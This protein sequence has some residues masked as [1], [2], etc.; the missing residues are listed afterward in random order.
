M[1]KIC[2]REDSWIIRRAKHESKYSNWRSFISQQIGRDEVDDK[3]FVDISFIR[4][5]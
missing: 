2:F 1:L 3:Q 5:Y 4:V